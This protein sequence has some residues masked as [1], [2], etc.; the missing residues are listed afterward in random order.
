MN[1]F[2][3]FKTK[4]HAE[5]RSKEN[6]ILNARINEILMRYGRPPIKAHDQKTL[7]ELILDNVIAASGRNCEPDNLNKNQ[8]VQE[9]IKSDLIKVNNIRNFLN[10]SLLHFASEN[11]D[12]ALCSLLV[13]SGADF[14]SEDNY[15]QSPFILAAKRNNLELIKLFSLMIQTDDLR[16]LR[17]ICRASYHAC[18]A[19]HLE[20]VKYLFETFKINSEYL[21]DEKSQVDLIEKAS[22]S[23]LNVLHVVCYK[24]NFETARYLLEKATNKE[25]FINSPINEFRESTCLEEAFKGLLAL[26][27]GKKVQTNKYGRSVPNA[28]SCVERDMK[29]AKY[30][31]I[32]NLLIENKG[33]FSKDFVRLNGLSKILLQ[34]FSG[35]NKDLDFVHFLD[36][37]KFLFVYKLNEIFVLNDYQSENCFNELTDEELLNRKRLLH[38]TSTKPDG[39]TDPALKLKPES[40]LDLERAIDEFLF[41]VYLIS[42]RVLKDYKQICLSKYVQIILNLHYSGQVNMNM[43]KFLYIKERNNDVYEQIQDALKK[44]HSLKNSCLVSIRNGIKCFG[45]NKINELQIPTALK[46][47]L[48]LNQMCPAINKGNISKLVENYCY[49]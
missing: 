21:L 10:Q 31:S 40:E 47:E 5:T 32:I 9:L 12:L 36:C 37:C 2:K 7:G 15:R 28:S 33:K 3:V 30:E 19:G 35:P 46:H 14:L 48:F 25:K 13:R 27:Y 18:C 29:R 17:Q 42:M 4:L 26:D 23:E 38:L 49:L 34:V 39:A 45:I 22:L 43:S 11:N 20:I 24:A 1:C 16:S 41:K 8:L 6:E 44:P